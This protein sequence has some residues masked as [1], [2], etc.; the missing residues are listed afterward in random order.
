MSKNYVIFIEPASLD[1]L[2]VWEWYN[3]DHDY[4]KIV[5]ELGYKLKLTR[6]NNRIGI[7]EIKKEG[8]LRV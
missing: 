6:I 7:Y 5:N 8:L 4:K 2:G 3:W 1:N